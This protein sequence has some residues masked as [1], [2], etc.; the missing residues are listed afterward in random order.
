[1]KPT[2]YLELLDR[3]PTVVSGAP[4]FVKFRAKRYSGGVPKGLKF[5]VFLYRKKF[6]TPQWVVEAG[7]GL[8][9]GTDYYGEVRSAT[10]LQEPKRIFSSIEERL[11]G[12]GDMSVANN[13]DSA[14]TVDESGEAEFEFDIPKGDS[15]A[16]GEWIYTLMV[17]AMDQAGSQAV[18]T[19]SIYMTLSEAQPM[20]RFTEPVAQVG[21]QGLALLV[22]STYADGK[23][24]PKGGGVLDIALE[25][26]AAGPKE[27]IKLPFT[28]DAQGT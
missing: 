26:G 5:E 27:F 10:A 8:S 21:D 18:L 11:A 17:R 20:V 22:R 16:E 9:A 14:P 24:A 3:S 6:E 28:T 15:D 4:F 19:D 1:M 13:W 2:F 23:P 12:M 25:Q 7:G